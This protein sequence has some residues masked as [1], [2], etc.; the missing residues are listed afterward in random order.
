M[1]RPH[2]HR[3]FDFGAQPRG[4]GDLDLSAYK[5]ETLAHANETKTIGDLHRIEAL[6]A[7]FNSQSDFISP[8]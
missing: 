8:P 3:R 6:S 5:S 7:V 2:W 4:R 1:R